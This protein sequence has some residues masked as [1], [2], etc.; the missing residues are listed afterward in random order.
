MKLLYN[1]F[2]SSIPLYSVLGKGL[3]VQSDDEGQLAAIQPSATPALIN[4]TSCMVSTTFTSSVSSA[5]S[6]VSVSPSNTISASPVTT[7]STVS[8]TSS[9]VAPSIT[10]VTEKP[11][12]G[13]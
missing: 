6:T 12:G 9:S 10:V 5:T 13:K 1:L 7:A 4:A 11:G 8:S 2:L 3:L